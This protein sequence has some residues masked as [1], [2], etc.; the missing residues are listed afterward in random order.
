M[1][2][3]N[4]KIL[5]TGGAGFIGHHIAQKL[6][7]L[8]A[9]VIIL[10]NLSSGERKKVDSLLGTYAHCTFIEGDICNLDTCLAL[11]KQIDFV[12]H[13]A[14]IAS[15]SIGET[16][17]DL[18]N[19]VNVLGT[20]NLFYAACINSVQKV[21]YA[22]SAAVY[23]DSPTPI[24]EEKQVPT[25]ISLYGL[26]KY[27]NEQQAHLLAQQFATHF[28]GLRYF[29]VYGPGQNPKSD[30]SGVISIFIDKAL[31]KE[32]ITIFGDGNA[33]RDFIYVEDIVAANLRSLE[34]TT[35]KKAIVYNIASGT[36]NTINYL[37][38]Q[39]QTLYA[40]VPVQYAPKRIGDI[41]H[42]QADIHVAEHEL[43]FNASITLSEG[44]A[45][46]KVLTYPQP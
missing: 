41:M 5:L 37:A 12:I 21:I 23:G 27:I 14:A 4:K 36:S 6:L 38:A 40:A 15:V 44:L 45:K 26:S 13:H 30:Y 9:Q 34:A 2:Y 11:T 7:D 24:K 28:I 43:D 46:M 16:N 17:P 8:G 32:P 31:A 42:S 10:D 29:N 1:N 35:E 18:L 20:Y 19:R 33:T 25:P 22:S 39:I 3:A